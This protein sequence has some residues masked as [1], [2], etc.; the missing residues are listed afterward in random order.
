MLMVP[1]TD[2][3]LWLLVDLRPG[4]LRDPYYQ[5]TAILRRLS[6][7]PNQFVHGGPPPPLG[8]RFARIPSMAVPWAGFSARLSPQ[9]FF[10]QRVAAALNARGADIQVLRIF[11]CFQL[12]FLGL[13]DRKSLIDR[14]VAVDHRR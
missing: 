5:H 12:R 10:F 6:R 13:A 8:P 7:L 1:M 14:H 9:E 2:H 11:E 4:I 3:H